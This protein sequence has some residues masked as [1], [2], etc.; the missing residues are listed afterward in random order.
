M[1]H[2][3]QLPAGE[4]E[5]EEVDEYPVVAEEEEEEV[6][7]DVV[8][9]AEV[10]VSVGTGI[11]GAAAVPAEQQAGGD[12]QGAAR[13]SSQQFSGYLVPAS[14][15]SYQQKSPPTSASHSAKLK[16][17]LTIPPWTPGSVASPTN[18]ATSSALDKQRKKT[19]AAAAAAKPVALAAGGATAA[20]GAAACAPAEVHEVTCSVVLDD[21]SGR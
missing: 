1:P 20:A 2:N 6:E 18:S 14:R 13:R 10:S 4:Q 12:S 19:A 8:A 15:G 16:G 7:E 9:P 21:A 11:D 5:C 17:K 3:A